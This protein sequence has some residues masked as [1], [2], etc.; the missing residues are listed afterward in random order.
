MKNQFFFLIVPEKYQKYFVQMK[1]LHIMACI[2]L[3]V[4]A[5]MLVQDWDK[6]WI[7]ITALIPA[8]LATLG[9]VIFKDEMLKHV[10]VNQVLRLFQLGFMGIA[11]VYFYD[12]AQWMPMVLFAALAVFLLI[13]MLVE[14]KIFGEQF[15]ELNA[16]EIIFPQ[17]YYT[18]KIPWQN[19]KNIILRFHVL[20]FELK[21]DSFI[22]QDVFH[23]YD[24]EELALFEDFLKR[25]L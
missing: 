17:L 21:D 13:L 10:Q 20:T 22:Q 1:A 14:N 2:F 5:L 12:L 19:I 23:K 16:D 4:Y 25:K 6:N 8:S 24:A 9:V 3:I 11:A 15:I 7:E 18:K